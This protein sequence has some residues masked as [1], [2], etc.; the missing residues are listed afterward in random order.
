MKAAARRG[1]PLVVGLLE[2]ELAVARGGE[3][4]DEEEEAIKAT[5]DWLE[6]QIEIDN[7]RRTKRGKY[8]RR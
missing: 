3:M 7:R 5:L 2:R 6:R 8:K 4:T 1:M